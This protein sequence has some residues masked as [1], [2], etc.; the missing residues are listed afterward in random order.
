MSTYPPQFIDPSAVQWT[1]VNP[2]PPSTSVPKQSR[3]LD[4]LKILLG[5]FIALLLAAILITVIVVPRSSGSI[6]LRAS[7]EQIAKLQR[8]SNENIARLQRELTENLTR[9]MH[10]EQS[11]E[12]DRRVQREETFIEK[13]RGEDQVI[14]RDQRQQ[15]LSLAMEQ[16][17]QHINIEERRIQVMLEDRKIREENRKEDQSRENADLLA[18]FIEEVVSAKE[19]LE[20]S[21]L[22]VKIDS[23]LARLD[24]EHKSSLISF[25]YKLRYIHGE[26]PGNA[27]LNMQGAF[28]KELDLD[29]VDRNSDEGKLLIVCLKVDHLSL[30]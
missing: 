15:D 2:I 1:T 8:E 7:N 20:D 14:Q 30:H 16:L 12:A 13:N 25:L 23:L 6:D 21:I 24:R 17:R 22:R 4:V 27:P 11:K 28:L 3:T 29:D 26:R 5:F 18:H 19:P 9:L 10:D